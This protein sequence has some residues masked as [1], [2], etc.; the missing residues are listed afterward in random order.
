VASFSFSGITGSVTLGCQRRPRRR[1]RPQGP[2][3]VEVE[4]IQ[5]DEA[6]ER[7]AKVFEL[8]ERS[9]DKNAAAESDGSNYEQ[10]SLFFQAVG[11]FIAQFNDSAFDSWRI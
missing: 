10:L 3:E 8:L 4:F 11:I 7:W 6:N 2:L 5:T 1:G 9:A